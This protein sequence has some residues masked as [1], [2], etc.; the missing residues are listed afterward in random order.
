MYTFRDEFD[1]LKVFE[2]FILCHFSRYVIYLIFALLT[3]SIVQ[4]AVLKVTLLSLLDFLQKSTRIDKNRQESTR[5]D[6]NRQEV[7]REM[8]ERTVLNKI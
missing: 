4:R 7:T 1:L 2:N 6:K 3:A 8:K 5:I